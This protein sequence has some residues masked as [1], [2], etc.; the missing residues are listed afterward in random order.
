MVRAVPGRLIAGVLVLAALSSAEAQTRRSTPGGWQGNRPTGYV[1]AGSI[2]PAPGS[3][4]RPS[5]SGIGRVRS[6]IDLLSSPAAARS[7]ETPL[8]TFSLPDRERGWRHYP[9]RHRHDRHHDHWYRKPCHTYY[10]PY[11]RYPIN[12]YDPVISIGSG[13]SVGGHGYSNYTYST[14]PA[15]GVMPLPAP[16]LVFDPVTG[17]YVYSYGNP[18]AAPPVAAPA[19]SAAPPVVAAEPPP[20]PP[21]TPLELARLNLRFGMPERAVTGLREHLLSSPDDGQA[22]RLLGLALLAQKRIDDGVA[23]IRQAYRTEPTLA[24]EPIHAPSIGLHPDELRRLVLRTVTYANRVDTGSAWLT[25]AVLMQSE[26]RKPVARTMLDRV[27][28]R[29]METDVLAALDEALQP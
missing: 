27:R 28:A 15:I 3:L 21:P 25:V 6:N 24:Y 16:A 14:S 29:G 19:P 5:H 10:D 7:F 11:Y 12:Y 9:R 18:N 8:P 13:L 20:P 26:G 23:A 2:G 1:G 22:L 17:T 4:A